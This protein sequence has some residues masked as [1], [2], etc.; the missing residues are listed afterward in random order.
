[1]C[2]QPFPE[3]YRVFIMQGSGQRVLVLEPVKGC[4]INCTKVSVLLKPTDFCKF[5]SIL[6]D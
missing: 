2:V 4:N 5:L 3:G 6:T 1:M